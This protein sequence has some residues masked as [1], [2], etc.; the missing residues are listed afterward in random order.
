VVAIRRVLC[1][2]LIRCLRKI[3][4]LVVLLFLEHTPQYQEVASCVCFAGSI[5]APAQNNYSGRVTMSDS[6][7]SASIWII[8][9]RL[10][11]S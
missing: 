3:S 9:E 8:F 10:V 7:P 4:T 1:L 6:L 5:L 2:E 11:P